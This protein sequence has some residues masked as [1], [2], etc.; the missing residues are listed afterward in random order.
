MEHLP[1][2]KT[3]KIYFDYGTETLDA[4]YL[5]YQNR[6]SEILKVKGY[7]ILFQVKIKDLMQQI[8]LKMLGKA[9]YQFLCFFV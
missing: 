9:D 3:H 4:Y 7:M 2:S 5:P 8:I 6:V 1:Q